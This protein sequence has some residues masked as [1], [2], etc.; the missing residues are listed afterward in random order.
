MLEAGD[1]WTEATEN[2][3]LPKTDPGWGGGYTDCM[4]VTWRPDLSLASHSLQGTDLVQKGIT[5]THG[6][7]IQGCFL[8]S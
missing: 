8:Q 3:S 7:E 6:T 1:V 4:V 5:L 2:H